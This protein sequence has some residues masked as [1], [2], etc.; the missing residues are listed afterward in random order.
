MSLRKKNLYKGNIL[1]NGKLFLDIKKSI[2]ILQACEYQNINIPRFCYHDNLSIAGNC[3]ICLIEIKNAP[4]LVTSCNTFLNGNMEIFTESNLVQEARQEIVEFLLINHPLDCP[5]C[6]Q[7]GECDLQEIT[8]KFGLN[9]SKFFFKKRGVEDHYVSDVVETIMTRCIH[10]TRCV[11]FSSEIAG[12]A[13]FHTMNRG[14]N[15]EIGILINDILNSELS[16]NLV[17]LCPVGALTLKT[18]KF[19]Q[20][21]WELDSEIIVD[22]LDS[23]GNKVKIEYKGIKIKRIL[24]LVKNYSSLNWISNKTRLIYDSYLIQRLESPVFNFKNNSK[25]FFIS[26]NKTLNFLNKKIINLFENKNENSLGFF[27]SNTL[28]LKTIYFYK[29]ILNKLGLDLYSENTLDRKNYDFIN[30]FNMKLN[31]SDIQKSTCCVLINTNPRFESSYINLLLKEHISNNSYFKVYVIGHPIKTTYKTEHLNINLNQIINLVD[32]KNKLSKILIKNSRPLILVNS[33]T[34]LNKNHEFIERSLKNIQKFLNLKKNNN[35]IKF[36][37]SVNILTLDSNTSGLNYLNIK[38]LNLNL[39]KDLRMIFL[40]NTQNFIAP[41]KNNSAL[42]IYQ[43]PYFNRYFSKCNLFLPVCNFLE[44][45]GSFINI[46]GKKQKISNIFPKF[47][48][49]IEIWQILFFIFSKIFSKIFYKDSFLKY[50]LLINPLQNNKKLKSNFLNF[51]KLNFNPSYYNLNLI[52]D[53]VVFNFYNTN[54][55]CLNSKNVSNLHKNF[56]NKY[57]FK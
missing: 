25:K 50:F 38:K 4:K 42:Y 1:I 36:W 28:D 5:I 52:S 16:G 53:T 11:R 43:G 9:S 55:I 8:F 46:E 48:N 22:L 32:G 18:T 31:L 2:S 13:Q 17:D 49:N 56:I 24:P 44:Q 34:H 41:Y 57:N 54:Q 40:L 15:T 30:S 51:N 27:C 19:N 12:D 37:D 21:F 23:V 26:W 33:E 29:T 47:K 3:R 35:F 20:R 7:G 10:C 39:Y 14:K 45:L 6:D